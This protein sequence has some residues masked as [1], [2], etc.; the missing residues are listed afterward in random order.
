MNLPYHNQ[1]DIKKFEN[2]LDLNHTANSYKILWLA[3]IIKRIQHHQSLIT[4][5]SIVFDMIID[6]YDY[7]SLYHLKYGGSDII[8]SI[9]NEYSSK[10]KVEFIQ[11]IKSD[12]HFNKKA[13]SLSKY[14]PYRLLTSFFKDE[15][16]GLSDGEKNL[17]ILYLSKHDTEC[18]YTIDEHSQRVFIHPAWKQYVLDNIPIIQAWIDYKL[19]M[20]LQ[21]R[22]PSIPNIPFKVNP[23]NRKNL[24]KQT[25]LW[26]K[27]I[28]INPALAFDLYLDCHF[29]EQTMSKHGGFS[30]DHFIP[31]SFVMHNELWNLVPIHKNINSLKSNRLPQQQ[32]I[33]KYIRLQYDFFITLRAFGNPKDMEDYLSLTS[34]LNTNILEWD[35]DTFTNLVHDSTNS[36]YKIAYN[37]GY[38]IWNTL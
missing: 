7:I 9:I 25:K 26:N 14:V 36:L 23:I 17:Q 8:P 18:F 12:K 31:Y 5:E 35:Q 10:T 28:T 15:L 22:N 13:S 20:F 38:S 34:S 1:L 6:S 29:N 2:M 4:F 32:F 27:A 3:S 33:P 24:T 19:I 37:H 21:R 11:A 16:R 30:L